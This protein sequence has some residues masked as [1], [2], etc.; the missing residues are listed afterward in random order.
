MKQNT[1]H[2]SHLT[3]SFQDNLEKLVSWCFTAISAQI[4]YIMP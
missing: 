2:E 3:A 1:S 4:G